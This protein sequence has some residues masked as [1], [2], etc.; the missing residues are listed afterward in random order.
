MSNKTL[1]TMLIILVVIILAGSGTVYYLLQQQKN[2]SNKGPTIDEI[3]KDSVDVTEFTTNLA[4]GNYVKMSFKI[5]T[6]SKDAA[7]EL[8]KREFQVRNIMIEELSNTTAKELEGKA[9][10]VKLENVLRDKINVIMQNGK[11]E[12]VYITESLIQ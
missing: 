11:I 8:T 4:G 12:K 3:I 5:Q 10:K 9:G 1:K 6:D 7:A 2:S